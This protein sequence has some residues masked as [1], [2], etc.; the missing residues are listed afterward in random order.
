MKLFRETVNY[1]Q[2]FAVTYVVGDGQGAGQ[3]R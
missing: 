2:V 3:G 1:E